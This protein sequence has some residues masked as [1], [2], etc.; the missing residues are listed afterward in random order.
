MAFELGEESLVL[1]SS[2]NSAGGRR[3]GFSTINSSSI[4]STGTILSVSLS[5]IGV[6][7]YCKKVCIGK[8]FFGLVK[9]IESRSLSIS[10][11]LFFVGIGMEYFDASLVS[12]QFKLNVLLSKMLVDG[13]VLS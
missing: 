7:R 13:L 5:K 3:W 8:S 9:S 4:V 12:I 2:S 6:V 11:S 10:I 1:L